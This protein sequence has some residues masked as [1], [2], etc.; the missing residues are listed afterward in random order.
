MRVAPCQLAGPFADSHTLQ[1]NLYP[2]VVHHRE[3]C[4]KALVFF[5][6]QVTNCTVALAIVKNTCRATVNAELVFYGSG[7][8]IIPFARI[9]ICVEKKLRHQ[10]QRDTTDTLRCTIDT[11]QHE[12]DD[13]L[14]EFV[15]TPGDVYLVAENSI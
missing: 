9:P 3:H 5:A 2:R 10:E 13:V 12:M 14:G 8:E 15:V 4:G 6:D 1:S 7:N 11:R